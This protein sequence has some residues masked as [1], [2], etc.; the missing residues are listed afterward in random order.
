MTPA[1]YAAVLDRMSEL[2]QRA[3]AVAGVVGWFPW[4]FEAAIGG[5]IC[6]G[7]VCPLKTRGRDKGLPNYR[8][9]I[10]DTAVVVIV[11]GQLV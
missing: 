10:K 11:T 1:E 7:A 8:R 9:A 3:A 5:V 4:M 2:D 6:R